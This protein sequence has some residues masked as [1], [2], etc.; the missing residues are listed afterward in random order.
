MGG[1]EGV[2]GALGADPAGGAEAGPGDDGMVV[3]RP[4]E[5]WPGDG[6]GGMAAPGGGPTSRPCPAPLG[7]GGTGTGATGWAGTPPPPST[8]TVPWACA[9]GVAPQLSTAKISAR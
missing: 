6:G 4:E 7:D 3:P 5:G 1:A 2:M 8:G 9:P